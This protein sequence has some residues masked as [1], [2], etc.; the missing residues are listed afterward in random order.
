MIAANYKLGWNYW[1]EKWDSFSSSSRSHFHFSWIGQNFLDEAA[2][3]KT[4]NYFLLA[5]KKDFFALKSN[6]L[7]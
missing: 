4:D 3:I 1:L 7:C 2:C 5:S 6:I